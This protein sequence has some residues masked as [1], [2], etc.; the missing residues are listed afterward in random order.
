MAK[1]ELT[2]TENNKG[3]TVFDID[4][5]FEQIQTGGQDRWVHLEAFL[6]DPAAKGPAHANGSVFAGVLTGKT[7]V[8]VGD[9]EPGGEDLPDGRRVRYF[10][11]LVLRSPCPVMWREGGKGGSIQTAI[12]EVGTAV[13]IGER[14]KL[15]ILR[16]LTEDG[17]QYL[18]V[19][20]PDEK[21]NVGRP[22]PM[23]T[24][25]VWKKVLRQPTVIIPPPS[26]GAE[27]P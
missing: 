11:T 3:L 18:V 13:N 21:I 6:E 16:P 1:K 7:E 4:D 22:Q 26:K 8:E 10:Y 27:F 20:K 17:G 24:F 14:T 5:S 9:D 25:G 2:I 12:A 15:R 19:I 23:W